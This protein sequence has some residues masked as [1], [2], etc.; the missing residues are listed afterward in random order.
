LGVQQVFN[1]Y[2]SININQ[3]V[4]YL[5]SNM[6]NRVE[7]SALNLIFVVILMLIFTIPMSYKRA[8]V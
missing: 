4:R 8:K 5:N 6:F 3:Y 1:I 7:N 2:D